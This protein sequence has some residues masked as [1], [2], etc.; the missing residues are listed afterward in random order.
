[1]DLVSYKGSKIHVVCLDGFFYIGLC[2]DADDESLTLIDKKQKRVSLSKNC[3][4][5]IKE[6]YF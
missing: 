4:S 5:A 1:M 3:I 2:V 6:V